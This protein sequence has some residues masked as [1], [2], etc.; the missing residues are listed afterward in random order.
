MW[1]SVCISVLDLL[2]KTGNLPI[3]QSRIPENREM[4]KRPMLRQ[5]WGCAFHDTWP[6]FQPILSKSAGFR[7]WTSTSAR[8]HLPF[9]LLGHKELWQKFSEPKTSLTGAGWPMNNGAQSWRQI[10]GREDAL[11]L[12]QQRGWRGGQRQRGS[13][14]T[15]GRTASTDIHSRRQTQRLWWQLH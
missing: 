7:A 10:V 9:S 11:L 14:R 13:R 5:M 1:Y 4:T 3:D 12:Q 15:K 2:P 6:L 8:Y